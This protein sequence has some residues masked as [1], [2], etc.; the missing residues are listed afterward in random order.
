[1]ESNLSLAYAKQ[2][3]KNI[4]GGIQINY[5]GMVLP[6]ENKTLSSVGAELGFIFRVTPRTFLGIHVANP[7]SVPFS[8]A[9]YS[10]K[11]PWNLRVGCH[12]LVSDH[13]TLAVEGEKAE[14]SNPVIKMGMEW[15][16]IKNFFFRSGFN[17]GSSKFFAG[18]GFRYHFV[19]A[20]LA[21][22]YNQYLGT[23]PVFSLTFDIK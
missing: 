6:E 2:L 20:D 4:S 11:I 18:L 22:N 7:F 12:Y 14:G 23:S 19:K 8:T 21:F 15:E 9:S 5:F 3:S 1:M 16:A 13:F 17:S 10:E